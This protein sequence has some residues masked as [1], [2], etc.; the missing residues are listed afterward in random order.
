VVFGQSCWKWASLVWWMII[1]LINL[2]SPGQPEVLGW[3]VETEV[4]SGESL[5]ATLGYTGVLREG[6]ELMVKASGGAAGGLL[7]IMRRDGSLVPERLGWCPSGDCP[8]GDL[9]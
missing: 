9:P 4:L 5:K 1:L 6:I 2:D 8:L 3:F 7:R